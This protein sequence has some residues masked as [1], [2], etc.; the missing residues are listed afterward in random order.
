[1]TIEK[2]EKYIAEL[3]STFL[4][5]SQI[6]RE[7]LFLIESIVQFQMLKKEEILLREGQTAKNVHF[8]CKGAVRAYFSDDDGNTYNKN[9]FLERNIA[10][11]TV[12]LLLNKPSH[13]TLQALEDCVI[14]NLNFKKYK[15]LINQHNDIKNFYIAYLEKNWVIE[16]EQREISLV[17][18][19]ATVRY[20][21]LLQQH[22]N[23]D[24]RISLLHIASHL[25]ITPTQLSRIRK[26]LNKNNK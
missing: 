14:I 19:N 15:G 7:S 2:K 10:G 5:Y 16:K 8:I 24:K 6:S 13:F 26:E 12:S 25:G 17:M 18:E 23:I 4:S 21:K 11:S 3:K 22:P 20:L 1:M 9:I